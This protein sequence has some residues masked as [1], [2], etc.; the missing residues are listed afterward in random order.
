[1][2]VKFII[3]HVDYNGKKWKVGYEA[4]TYIGCT[5]G[6]LDDNEIAVTLKENE[7]PFTGIPRHKIEVVK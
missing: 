7:T 3:S 1:M 4:Y 6:C 2:K 5:Y